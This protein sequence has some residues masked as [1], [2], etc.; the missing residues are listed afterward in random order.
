[1]NSDIVWLHKWLPP[2]MRPKN[3][4]NYGWRY[5]QCLSALSVECWTN[6]HFENGTADVSSFYA[7]SYG[8]NLELASSLGLLVFDKLVLYPYGITKEATN[9]D[10]RYR[11]AKTRTV[12]T[13]SSMLKFCRTRG[14]SIPFSLGAGK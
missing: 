13:Y 11:N 4:T 12:P 10:V 8:G 7:L 6:I 2:A 9:A 14:L 5:I 3:K 1:M